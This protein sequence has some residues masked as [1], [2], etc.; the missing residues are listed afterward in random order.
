M[1]VNQQGTTIL[2]ST[3]QPQKNVLLKTAVSKV[4]SGYLATEANVLFAEGAQRSFITEKLASEL[5]IVHEG[6]DLINLISFGDTDKRVRRLDT[7]T[8]Y[9][10]SEN[11]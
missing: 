4:S 3:I 8:M 7:A 6:S 2:H 9:V 10:I 11:D 1:D 5:D